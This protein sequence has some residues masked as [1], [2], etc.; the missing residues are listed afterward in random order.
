MVEKEI[1]D[2][3]VV[4]VSK[5]K[6]GRNYHNIKYKLKTNA[7]YCIDGKN[8]V[9]YGHPRIVYREC[10]SFFGEEMFFQFWIRGK[11]KE[12]TASSPYNNIEWYFKTEAGVDFLIKATEYIRNIRG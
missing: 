5:D 4:Q 12:Y 2:N 10:D 7:I 9:F 1:A 6:Q 8:N 11:D 3:I